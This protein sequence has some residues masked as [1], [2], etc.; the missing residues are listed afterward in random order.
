MDTNINLLAEGKSLRVIYV[1]SVSDDKK[2]YSHHYIIEEFVKKDTLGVDIWKIVFDTS[3]M[4][5]NIM[6]SIKSDHFKQLLCFINSLWSR[7]QL[8]IVTT[9]PGTIDDSPEAPIEEPVNFF[10]CF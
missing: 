5:N 6:I 7:E 4:Q 3:E 8:E 9:K 10:S 1:E 2:E